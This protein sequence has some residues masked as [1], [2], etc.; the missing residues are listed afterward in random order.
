MK[1]VPKQN[2]IMI[3]ELDFRGLER[4]EETFGK[5]AHQFW[6]VLFFRKF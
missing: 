2:L 1:S 4:V 3:T 5:H 6:H